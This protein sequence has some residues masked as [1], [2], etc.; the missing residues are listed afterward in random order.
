MA[1][2]IGSEE[3]PAEFERLTGVPWASLPGSARDTITTVG[4]AVG[5]SM[6]IETGHDSSDNPLFQ[7]TAEGPRGDAVQAC[8][9]ARSGRY[10]L[11]SS[12][13]RRPGR[14]QN[15]SLKAIRSIATK[16]VQ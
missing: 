2:K 14:W 8:W 12:I 15:A 11:A 10:T 1:A 9:K 6:R 3:W 16:E 5:W 13:C 7:V 4:S